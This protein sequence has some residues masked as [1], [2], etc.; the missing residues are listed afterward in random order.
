[1]PLK[2]VLRVGVRLSDER[3]VTKFATPTK[4]FELDPEGGQGSLQVYPESR[5]LGGGPPVGHP[6]PLSLMAVSTSVTNGGI[7]LCH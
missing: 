6:P 2:Y 7:H 3:R 1:M 5:M 4:P